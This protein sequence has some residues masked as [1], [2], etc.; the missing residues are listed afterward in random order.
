MSRCLKWV[1]V[2]DGEPILC[3]VRAIPRNYLFRP[4]LDQKII[5]KTQKKITKK[6]PGWAA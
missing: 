5:K 1:A 6:S 3:E 4:V 2:K